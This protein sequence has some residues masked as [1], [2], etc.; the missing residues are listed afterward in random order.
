MI[1][2][3]VRVEG[4]DGY[5]FY[6]TV[7]APD[8]DGACSMAIEHAHSDLVPKGARRWFQNAKVTNCERVKAEKIKPKEE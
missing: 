8:P 7:L 6:L 3:R 5:V 1:P 4:A 2:W